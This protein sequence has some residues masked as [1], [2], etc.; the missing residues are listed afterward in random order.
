MA[1]W[2]RMLAAMLAAWCAWLAAPALAASAFEQALPVAEVTAG[3]DGPLLAR[4][5]RYTKDLDAGDAPIERLLTVPLRANQGAAEHFGVPGQRTVLALKV[6]NAGP[7]AGTWILTTGRGSLTRFR[8]YTLSGAQFSLLLDGADPAAAQANLR[9]YQAFST[10][11]TLDPGETRTIVVDFLSDN[12]TYLPLRLETYSTFF[13][14]RRANIALVSGV[15]LAIGVL[16]FI[17]SLFFSITGYREF[18]WLALAQVFF[19]VSTVHTEG[20]L[21]IFF[22]ADSPLLSVAIEDGVKCGFTA[23]MAQFARTFLQT[24][25][26]F[27]R[28]DRTLLMLTATALVVVL[29]QFGLALYSPGL[30]V[31][32][33]GFAWAVTGSV[34]LFLPVVGILAV[35]HIGRQMWPLL[36]GWG[37]LA[38]FIIYGAVASMGVFS[39]L[40]INWHAIGPVG[41]FEVLM[42]TLA[43]GLNLR[44]IEADRRA[45]DARYAQS[46][47]ERL[48]IS[49]RAA[50]LYEE[51]EF[52]LTAVANQ[53]AL[54]HASGHDSRQVILALNS[55][56]SVLKRSEPGTV[57]RDLAEMLQS[58]ADYLSEIAATTMSGASTLG[59]QTRFVALSA[60]TGD[61]LIEP[62]LMMFKGP[63]GAKGLTLE[64]HTDRTVTIISDRP[65]LMRALANLLSNSLQHTAQGGVDVTLRSKDG[66]AMIDITDTGSGMPREV[67]NQLMHGGLPHSHK[68]GSMGSGSGFRS[69][70]QIIEGLGG[71]LV[72]VSS[73]AN[74]TRV[75]VRLCCAFGQVT[76]CTRGELAAR[77]EGWELA[78]FDERAPIDTGSADTVATRTGPI[79]AVTHDDRPVTRGRISE[80]AA[81]MLIKPLVIEMAAHPAM[82]RGS[83]Q[84]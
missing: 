10:E 38:V 37:S 67:V 45:A 58:S 51:R 36:V 60:F 75:Q 7:E 35:R 52:A 30:R 77:L 34:A 9:A 66:D 40:P 48:A 15:V 43:L 62:L 81:L 19:A 3:Q 53:N 59:A 46:I 84:L 41:L 13:Q 33:H 83:D 72:I 57:H 27:P 21:T 8:L 79:V 6:R 54:L 49:E 24:R 17:N 31:A 69:A 61:A 71:T 11:L 5:V 47:A 18:G 55:A 82:Q 26:R 29:L 16:V 74:G 70:R 39:W 44:K 73:D 4:Y 65:L 63:F 20:Y 56:V 28:L 23:A 80:R 25:E 22:L 76:P 78:D 50:R 64:A 42:V 12:S 14:D 68:S 32:L 1:G 2:R